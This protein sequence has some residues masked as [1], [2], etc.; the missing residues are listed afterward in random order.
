MGKDV[1]GAGE[2]KATGAAGVNDCKDAEAV[3]LLL[4]VLLNAFAEGTEGCKIVLGGTTAGYCVNVFG[5]REG[6]T[7]PVSGS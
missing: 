3:K 7:E 1:D 5:L 4:K 2:G 6:K